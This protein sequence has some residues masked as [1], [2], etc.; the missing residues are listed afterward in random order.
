MGKGSKKKESSSDEKEACNDTDLILRAIEN[1]M[2]VLS[3]RF[4]R[5]AE[6]MTKMQTSL[7]ELARRFFEQQQKAETISEENRQ[8]R[9][10][11]QII[12]D[13]IV[14]IKAEMNK[15]IQDKIKNEVL[16]THLPVSKT[17]NA[18]AVV[19][20]LFQK[21]QCSQ[22]EVISKYSVLKMGTSTKPGFHQICL[23]FRDET[24]KRIFLA[25]KKNIGPIFWSHIFPDAIKTAVEDDLQVFINE[26]LTKFNLDLI[27]EARK[28]RQSGLVKFAW[29]QNGSVLIRRA[30]NGPIERIRC[31]NDLDRICGVTANADD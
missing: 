27:R 31:V 29:H 8:L 18:D 13:E 22:H 14:G 11:Y 23:K 17:I 28:R 9:S 24:S 2:K 5:Q 10:S 4:E 20:V 3:D 25:K 21:M 30:E 15:M 6:N 12:S 16:I 26:K 19:D 7:N 1:S